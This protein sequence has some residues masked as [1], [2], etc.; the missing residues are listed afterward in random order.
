VES[1]SLSL[2]DRLRGS[3]TPDDWSRLVRVYEPL[4]RG[5]IRRQGVQEHDAADLTQEVLSSVV[6]EMPRFEYDPARGRFCSWLR[7]ITLNR[8]RAF[9]KTQARHTSVTIESGFESKLIELADP[10]SG[11]SQQ[12]DRE[13]D[14][15]L[16]RQAMAAVRTE[17][18]PATWEAFDRV[19]IQ[20]Q[21]VETAAH[22]LGVTRNVV[23]IAQ[24]RV[25]AR[26]REYVRGMCEF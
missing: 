17:F 5:W 14:A 15:H 3:P 6:R 8:L 18:K 23:Y 12:W 9:W 7:T 20:G 11:L 16:L 21:P 2:L 19:V 22:E 13:H 4:I 24:S 26:L 1:T 10:N 25:L